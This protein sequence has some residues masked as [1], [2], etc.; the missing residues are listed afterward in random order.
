MTPELLQLYFIY[1]SDYAQRAQAWSWGERDVRNKRDM[2]CEGMLKTEMFLDY[3]NYVRI[4]N[5]LH[6][7]GLHCGTQ[8][9]VR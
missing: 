3:N 1:F 9:E 8:L 6:L 7:I 5:G 2:L 4:E